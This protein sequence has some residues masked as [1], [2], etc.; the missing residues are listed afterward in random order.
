[1][2]TDKDRR[3]DGMLLCDAPGLGKTLSVLAA[4]ASTMQQD[5]K[6]AIIFA[7]KGIIDNVWVSQ[8]S[9]HFDSHVTG[10]EIFCADSESAKHQLAQPLNTRAADATAVCT[11][12][13]ARRADCPTPT[14]S[15][16]SVCWCLPRKCSRRSWSLRRTSR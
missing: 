15:A 3:A 6:P 10:L 11:W 9:R 12:M 4:I 14:V 1:M 7:G 5:K 2:A 16:A 8:I 13:R